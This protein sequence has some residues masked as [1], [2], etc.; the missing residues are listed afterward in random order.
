MRRYWDDTTV[1]SQPSVAE[2]KERARESVRRAGN[3][4]KSFDPVKC[5]TKRGAVCESWWGQ[6]WC[7]NLE[8]YADY[9]SRLDRG[10]GYVRS[11]AVIDL[12]ITDGHVMAKVQGRRRT[13]YKVEIRIGRLTEENCQKI[14]DRCT[15]RIESLETLVRGEFPEELKDIFT[16]EGGLFPNPREISFNCS[17]PDWAMMCKHVAAVM[18]GIGIRFDENPFYFFNLRGIDP[19]RF[20]GVALENSV[21]KMLK[22]ADVKTDRIINDADMTEL[23][24]VL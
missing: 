11:G 17:C 9:A 13:P 4:G 2:L 24:G 19:D 10:K 21:E 3:K 18:Y 15:S 20:I 1:Y 6:A 8:Q 7:N 12:Q 22:N 16:E 23:F 5:T 14:I